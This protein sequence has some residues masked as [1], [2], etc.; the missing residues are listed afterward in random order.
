MS[1]LL[2]SW[3]FFPNNARSHW[4]LRGHVTSNNETVSRQIAAKSMT[5]TVLPNVDRRPLLRTDRLGKH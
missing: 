2:Y 3:K 5:V 1:Q 4:L